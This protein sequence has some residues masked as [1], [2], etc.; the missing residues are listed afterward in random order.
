MCQS[1][2][3]QR[4]TWQKAKSQ[5]PKSPQGN[6]Q[7]PTYCPGWVSLFQYLL[8][9]GDKPS[10]WEPH[11][12]HMWRRLSGEPHDRVPTVGL[13][14]MAGGVALLHVSTE[15]CL[16]SMCDF[17]VL[18]SYCPSRALLSHSRTPPSPFLLCPPFPRKPNKPGGGFLFATL[19]EKPSRWWRILVL[20]YH[21]LLEL[22][23]STKQRRWWTSAKWDT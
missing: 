7:A 1:I 9:P 20:V 17:E 5:A 23:L 11:S 15:V 6:A 16:C 8:N 12:T 10:C 4:G 21:L 14:A 19:P 2:Q 3:R 18:T 13:A 22:S